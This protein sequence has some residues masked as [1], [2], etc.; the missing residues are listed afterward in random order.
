MLGCHPSNISAS[1]GSGPITVLPWKSRACSPASLSVTATGDMHLLCA[2]CQSPGTFQK[3]L[4]NL[5][6]KWKDK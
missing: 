1:G 5:S 6:Y 2:D 4:A 3:K